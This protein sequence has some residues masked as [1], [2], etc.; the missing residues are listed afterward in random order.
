MPRQQQQQRR[1][2]DDSSTLQ[3]DI[4][5]WTS[6]GPRAERRIRRWSQVRLA[7]ID[8]R[9]MLRGHRPPTKSS[10]KRDA[11]NKPPCPASGHATP[12]RHDAPLI[13]TELQDRLGQ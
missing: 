10:A 13:N 1:Q 7:R 11:C 3:R 2:H 8:R 9:Q 6:A 5:E 12:C 4:P